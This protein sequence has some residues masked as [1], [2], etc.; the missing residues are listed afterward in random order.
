MT[1]FRWMMSPTFPREMPNY[2]HGTAGI[3]DF[4][5]FLDLACQSDK[6]IAERYDRRFFQGALKGAEYLKMLSAS[7]AKS[8]MIPHNFPDGDNLFYLGWCHGPAGTVQFLERLEK[9]TQDN[10][11][12]KLS[13]EITRSLYQQGL[14]QVRTEGFWNNAGLCCGNAGLA[15]F[16][17]DRIEMKQETRAVEL[18]NALTSDILQRATREPLPNGK[19]GLYWI[20]A[21][22]RTR[23]D[24]LQAQ[25]GLMQGA[26]GI[27]MYFV[28]RHQF[29]EGKKLAS[30]LP[31]M[32]Y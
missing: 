28:R 18:A 31:M 27:G 15:S 16:L 32:P 8:G 3:C 7:S 4:L 30:D 11:W 1:G 2:S 29:A 26:A 22:H 12:G 17:L 5:L 19:I 10:R 21:E 23:P 24:F 6:T 14:P 13:Q 25:T 20:H 9:Q